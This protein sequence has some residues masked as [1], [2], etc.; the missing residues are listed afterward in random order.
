MTGQT[1]RTLEQRPYFFLSYAHVPRHGP[2]DDIDPDIWVVTLFDDLCTHIMQLTDVPL[3]G[4]PGFMDRDSRKPGQWVLTRDEALATCRVFVPLF[5]P[6]YFPSLDCGREWSVFV[7]RPP[8]RRGP[9]EAIV[10]ALWA[11][12][13]ADRVP[14]VARNLPA[15]DFNAGDRYSEFGFYGLIKLARHRPDYYQ[16]IS[17]LAKRII[18]TYERT[19]LP[20]GERRIVADADSAF[21]DIYAERV[22]RISV[23][24]PDMNDVPPGRTT[25]YYG[26]TALEW[27]PYRESVNEPLAQRLA[28]ELELREIHADIGTFADHMAQMSAEHSAS[29][30]ILVIDPWALLNPSVREGLTRYLSLFSESRTHILVP[31]NPADPETIER[32]EQLEAILLE[33]LG[34]GVPRVPSDLLT[35]ALEKTL[36]DVVRAYFTKAPAHPPPGEPLERP[37]LGRQRDDP[38]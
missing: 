3:G 24:A 13:P 18:E 14:A 15:I 30:G 25:Y 28:L 35:L 29:P 22:V 36:H 31:W 34:G 10:P 8:G 12:V 7:R 6:R 27:N 33:T 11:P 4:H 19:R 17:R 21:T 32:Q 1:S 5:S 20:V 23:L 2:D 9:A 38:E 37:R 16:A 26:R